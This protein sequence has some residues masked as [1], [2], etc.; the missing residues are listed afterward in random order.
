MDANKSVT[1]TFSTLPSYTLTVNLT[2]SGSGS[3]TSNPPGVTC[4]GAT[5]T[6]SFVS[7]TNVALTAVPSNS[8]FGGWSGLCTG[9]SICNV[10]MNGPQS[11]TATFNSLPNH[12]LTV[13]LAG[14]GTGSVAATVG[15]SSVP[16]PCS[17]STC[18]GSF[19]QGTT[20]NLTATPTSGHT[21]AGWSG[22]GCA[23]TGVCSVAMNSAQNVTATFTAPTSGLVAN[24]QTF[25]F[26]IRQPLAPQTSYRYIV[27]LT[28]SAPGGAPVT[29]R[30]TRYPTYHD[31]LH[32][33]GVGA[34][35]IY[36]RVDPNTG[37]VTSG[38]TSTA[39][40]V[41]TVA[42]PPGDGTVSGAPHFV[43]V[44]VNC[45]TFIPGDS[46]E[47]VAVDAQGNES[48]P[49]TVTMTQKQALCNHG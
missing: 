48:A 21:F 19:A 36:K 3:V 11:V 18:T 26:T 44:P 22:A 40:D 37:A 39:A 20:V 42:M 23:G 15:G 49:A 29:F 13:T 35:N 45:H 10:L 17:G 32:G 6:G 4:S 2:G 46:F 9:T 5:C 38:Y 1:A 24:P 34:G 31:P 12:V 47:F 41:S 14:T 28:G 16:L 30:I 25:Q 33:H 43:Y 7:G 8:V 27:T